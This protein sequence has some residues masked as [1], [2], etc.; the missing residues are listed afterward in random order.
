M[1]GVENIVYSHTA[2][3]IFKDNGKDRNLISSIFLTAENITVI[4][5]RYGLKY[6]IPLGDIVDFTTENKMLKYYVHLE[7]GRQSNRYNASIDF[8]TKS[9]GNT[10]ISL[11]SLAIEVDRKRLDL[12]RKLDDMNNEV[13]QW[14]Q[15]IN[16]LDSA[17]KTLTEEKQQIEHEFK[18]ESQGLNGKLQKELND[19]YS[20]KRIT[21]YNQRRKKQTSRL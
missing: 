15:Q 17:N 16:D 19:V 20:I 5:T 21:K 12:E 11:L 1:F 4:N 14:K 2:T 10:F 8:T 18:D 3:F 13:N 7:Y 6:R 9:D